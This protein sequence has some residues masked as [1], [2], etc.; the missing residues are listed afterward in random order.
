MIPGYQGAT[1]S[2]GRALAYAEWGDPDGFPV[3]SLHGTPGSRLG[4][5]YDESAYVDAG[6][7]VITYDRPGYGGSE[8]HPAR[9]VVD[10][11]DDVR[12]IADHL[13][14]D[15]FAVIGG[16]GGG[17][18][19][20]AVAAR[21]PGRVTR[22]TCAV[23]IVPYETENFDFFAGMDPNNVKEFGW[24]LEGETVLMPELEREAAEV[25]ERV[26]VD[27]SK[28]ISDDWDLS[29]AD[30]A[31]LARKERHD[32]IRQWTSEAFRNG[33]WGWVDD[34][35]CFL[36]PW[37]VDVAEVGV[38]TRVIYGVSDVLVPL[39]HGEWLAH[40]VPGAEVVVEEEKGHLPDPALVTERYEWLVQ[41][42]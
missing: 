15:H 31:E 39:Q 6:A 11:V 36:K 35:L 37:G 7:R 21:L 34:D 29:E 2:D 25:L 10:C 5:H 13:G 14:I 30:R 32:I 41:P 33:V 8:R 24:A 27:P 40:N 16:S 4:R 26:A 1:A 18:H 42:V 20:L 12:A 28:L 22:A 38:P 9:R 17:P 3:F 19:A 23:G